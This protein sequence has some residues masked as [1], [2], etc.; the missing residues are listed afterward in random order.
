MDRTDAIKD[1]MYGIIR[2]VTE[3]KIVSEFKAGNGRRM[4]GNLVDL[5]LHKVAPLD[6]E[7]MQKN[8]TVMTVL[9]HYL[10]STLMIPTQRKVEVD[11]ILLDM[12]MP[13][14]KTLRTNWNSCLIICIIESTEDTYVSETIARA[15][16]L[17]PN[18]ANI[19]VVSP[20]SIDLP[21]KTFVIRDSFAGI[22][23]ELN[24]F[25]KKTKSSRFKIFKIS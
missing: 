24:Q 12:V 17:Q 1:A 6:G 4:L 5:C 16:R 22:I 10:C 15:K 19:W 8:A 23:D 14:I 11:G 21:F 13:D 25:S 2:D 7:V 9:L 18:E 3:D 20:A